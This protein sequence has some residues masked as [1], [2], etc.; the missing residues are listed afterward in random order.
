MSEFTQ[1]TSASGYNTKNMV[2]SDVQHGNIPNSVPQINYKR[3]LIQTKNKDG[4]IG[5]LI[6]GTS[7]LFSF[8]VSENSDMKTG[9]VNG[10]VMPLCLW[11][12]NGATDEE[13][14][15]TDTFNAIV[16]KCKE[17]LVKSREDIE[18]YDLAMSDLKRF[19]PLYWKKER[20][21][22]VPG[23]GPTLYAK[24]IRSKKQ[25]KI[26]TMFFDTDGS[27]ITPLDLKGK[28]CYANCAIKIES[29]FIGNRISL[30]VKLY[31]A[32]VKMVEM[33]MRSLLRPGRPRLIT[34]NNKNTSVDSNDEDDSDDI[35]SDGSLQDSDESESETPPP[36]TRRVRK[37]TRAG[38]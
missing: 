18:Q 23:T 22:V 7:R 26:V 13:K 30:Q 2:F 28:Y 14:A 15:W 29:I 12:K 1:L 37:V 38:K 34:Q 27:P 32:E 4:T 8:G 16:D 35:L 33:G 5:D 17:H 3:I 31:E 20:G 24:L 19:N 11:N 36:T 10:Y 25:N 6:L 21:K 9:E